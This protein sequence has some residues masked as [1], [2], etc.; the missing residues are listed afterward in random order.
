MRSAGINRTQEETPIPIGKQGSPALGRAARMAAEIGP[1]H[2]P[3]ESI[4]GPASPALY[5]LLEER[6]ALE[7][8]TGAGL[9]LGFYSQ[10][11]VESTTQAL[12]W[13]SFYPEFVRLSPRDGPPLR[14]SPSSP[15]VRRAAA[16]NDTPLS[17][18]VAVNQFPEFRSDL[19]L[20]V[21]LLTLW[22]PPG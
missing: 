14:P 13:G 20:L 4:P 9:Y 19:P 22:W 12:I 10:R 16:S 1:A 17:R 7:S 15:R 6:R 18:R 8:G 21:P 3:S 2:R 5:N 11:H